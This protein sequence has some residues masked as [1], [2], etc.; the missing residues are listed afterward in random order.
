MNLVDQCRS[1]DM[2]G[3]KK[4]AKIPV[5][6]QQRLLNNVFCSKC[7]VTTIVDYGIQDDQSGL[8]LQGHCKKCGESVARFVEN[9]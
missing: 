1:S 3:L 5:D 4:W 9:D 6:M 8:V 2:E 7:G